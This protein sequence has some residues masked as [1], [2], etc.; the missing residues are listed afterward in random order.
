MATN[1]P[2]KTVRPGSRGPD[3]ARQ[4]AWW[5]EQLQ[6]YRDS[7]GRIIL[8]P[9]VEVPAGEAWLWKNP[10]AMRA[11]R[12]GLKDSADGNVV[13]RGRFAKYADESDE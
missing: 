12:Q 3:H 11:V 2:R 13:E 10:S 8:E 7:R 6:L 1:A 4:A 9:Q 5:R